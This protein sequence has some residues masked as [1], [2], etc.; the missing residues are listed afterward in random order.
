M[1]LCRLLAFA[2]MFPFLLATPTLAEGQSG[3]QSHSQQ[4]DTGQQQL[5]EQDRQW[6][7]YAATD[8]QAEIQECLLAEKKAHSPAV[9]AFARLMVDDHINVESRL[10]ALVNG[11]SV[12]VPNGTGQKNAKTISELESLQGEQFDHRF[13][14]EQIKDHGDD[15]GKF[16]DE[17]HATHDP[18]I[19]S[20]ASET[21]PILQQHLALAKAVQS[22]VSGHDSSK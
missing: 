1:R 3:G 13:L 18:N 17:I 14:A 9:K 11:Q 5:S 21:L 15:L 7:N 22:S 20:Y 16:S 10:A 4:S 12:S 19:R 6:L 2:A 8:N